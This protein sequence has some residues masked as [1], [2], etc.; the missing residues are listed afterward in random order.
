LTCHQEETNPLKKQSLFNLSKNNQYLISILA[1]G[2]VA[3]IGLFYNLIVPYGCFP[4]ACNGFH[5][6][7]VYGYRSKFYNTFNSLSHELRTP[8]TTIL[9]STDNLI[10]NAVNLSIET[11][12][13]WYSKKH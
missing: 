7:N 12:N 5:P 8:I 2:S 1:V 4:A 9:G 3:A 11:N 10:N 13:V 6:C